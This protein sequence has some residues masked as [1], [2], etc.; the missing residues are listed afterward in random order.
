MQWPIVDDNKLPQFWELAS[1]NGSKQML[2]WRLTV[3]K[4]VEMTV[5]RELMTNSKMIVRAD[6]AVS[7]C[8]PLHLS[9]GALAPCSL[10]VGSQT[11][12]RMALPVCQHP[13][14]SKLS[15]PLTVGFWAESSQTTLSVTTGNNKCS[16]SLLQLLAT[17]RTGE[18]V[19][20]GNS[21]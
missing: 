3:C 19:G 16:L 1:R 2:N 4:P 13:K 14:W 21:D 17:M 8:R 15:F 7:A 10:V 12:D 6:C 9:T 11:L 5:V 20:W 18:R